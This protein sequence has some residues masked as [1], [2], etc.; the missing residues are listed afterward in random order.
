MKQVII[1]ILI[2]ISST[3]V[4]C[5]CPKDKIHGIEKCSY[6][7]ECIETIKDIRLDNECTG[8]ANIDIKIDVTLR[9]ATDSFNLKADT[10]FLSMITTLRMFGNWPRTDLPFLDSMHRLRNVYLT[11]SNMQ[12]INDSPFRNLINLESIDLSHNS[13]SEIEELFQ[14]DIR[15]FKMRKLSLAF[16]LIEEV[17]GY[18]FEALTSLQELDLSHNLIK[19]L[20]EEP[21]CNLTNLVVLRLNN[22]NIVYLNGAMNN[23]TNLQHLYLRYNQIENID[24]ESL[25][26]INHLQ[27]FDISNNKIEILQPII[28]SRHWD[29]FNDRS[30]FRIILSENRIVLLHNATDFYDRFKKKLLKNEVQ[31][32]TQ[33][34]LSKNSISHIEYNAF[35]SIGRLDSLDLSNNKLLSFNVNSE[36]LMYVK[37]LN[38]S[39]NSLNS[40]YYESFSLMHNLQNLDLSHN[41][42]DYFPDQSLSNTY[43]L[44]NLNVTYNYIE[45][46]HNLR[47]TFHSE[48]GVLDLSNNGLSTIYIPVDEALGLTELI[49]SSNNISDA[50]L[51][52]LADQRNLTKLDMSKN[53][54]QEL[55]ESSLQLPNSIVCLDLSFND[56]QVIGP[57]AFHRVK[58]LKTLRLSHN[59][60]KTIEFGVFRGLTE[61]LNL[62][63]SYNEI[64]MLDSKVFMDLKFLSVLS[65]RHNGLNFID[66]D[67]WLTHKHNLKVYLDDNQLSC[68]WLA[69]ALSDFNN[70]Y[71]KMYPTVLVS[72]ISGHSIEGIPCKQEVGFISDPQAKYMIDERLLITSQKI[73]KAVQDQTSFLSKFVLRSYRHGADPDLVK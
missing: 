37:Y 30:I 49:L 59:R 60:I 33:L 46:I 5:Y 32:I 31:L 58:Q 54:I 67:S 6:R 62:D 9:N 61:L 4:L 38:L 57:S 14:F 69:K 64:E 55:D 24:M 29:H 18:T 13:L 52:R 7:I 16:N 20:S 28:F 23:L 22:N 26:T 48:G 35:H 65:L 12:K 1:I 53:F 71:S 51:I 50:Y 56:I 43:K 3:T 47:I 11:Y 27:T 40:L 45:E 39:C 68:D 42:M 73:L 25:K 34:D 15:P 2:L 63:L 41:L 36:D 70:G 19:E 8:A 72:T 66:R 10:D 44:K 21:F 17:P